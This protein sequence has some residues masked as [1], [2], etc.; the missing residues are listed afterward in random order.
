M[1]PI[2]RVLMAY[3]IDLDVDAV[4]DPIRFPNPV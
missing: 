4:T 3:A 1:S 2:S